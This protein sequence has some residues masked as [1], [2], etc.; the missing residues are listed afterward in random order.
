MI[1]K[2]ITYKDFNGVDRTEDFYFHLSKAELMEMELSVNNG[3]SEYMK[4]I[5]DAQDGK[6]IMAVTKDVILKSYGEKSIDGRF[7][8]KSET[9]SNRF[10]NSPAYDVLFAELVTDANASAEFFKG[11]MPEDLDDFAEK[12]SRQNVAPAQ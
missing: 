12:T 5:V 8:D 1:K 9:L 11:I 10:Y 7:F 4:L 2:T 6:Q 3:L